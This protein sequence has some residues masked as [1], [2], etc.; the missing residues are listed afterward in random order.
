M[1]STIKDES[2]LHNYRTEIPN[3]LLDLGLKPTQLAVYL[4]LKR[5]AGDKGACIKSSMRLAK[6]ANVDLKTYKKK[7]IIYLKYILY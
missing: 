5:S 7:S 4:A 3:I 6:E 2:S 1:R